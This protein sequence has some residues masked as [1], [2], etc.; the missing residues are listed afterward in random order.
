[1]RTYAICLSLAALGACASR[2][3]IQERVQHASIPVMVGCVAGD[4]P[5]IVAP[6]SSVMTAAEWAKRSVKQKAA[7]VGRQA[8]QHQTRAEAL[9]AATSACR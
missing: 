5:A 7:L 3:V 6:L 1:M 8:L 4:R 9:A 2:T